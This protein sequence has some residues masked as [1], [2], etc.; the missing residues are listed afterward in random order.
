MKSFLS[1]VPGSFDS[2]EEGI[3]WCDSCINDNG[4]P[5]L[6]YDIG[7]FCNLK[8]SDAG[9]ICTDSNRCQGICLA[10]NENSNSGK[11]SDTKS[12]LGCVSEMTDGKSLEICFD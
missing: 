11:C 10:E 12:V 3:K 1:K 4:I 8:T 9:E 6:S 5:T 7:P 2:L